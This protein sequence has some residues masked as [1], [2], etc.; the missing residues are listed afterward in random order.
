MKQAVMLGRAA[1]LAMLLIAAMCLIQPS[2]AAARD[3]P[4]GRAALAWLE[5]V[6]QGKYQQSWQAAGPLFQKA[7][8]AEQWA[9]S[10]EAVRTP[11]GKVLSRKEAARQNH[12]QLPGA[13]DGDYMVFSYRTSFA[14]KAQAVETFTLRRQPDGSWR[15]AGYYIR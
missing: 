7:V 15:A 3:D 6:D 12:K 9:G 5:L 2:V 4:A 1:G 13:P 8:S 10:L 14:N 11:L